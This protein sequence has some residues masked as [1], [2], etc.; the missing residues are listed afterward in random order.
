[1]SK[2]NSD[3][4]ALNL[5]PQSTTVMS[6]VENVNIFSDGEDIS[7]VT[8]Y[9]FLVVLITND[10]YN[11]EQIKKLLLLL[12]VLPLL[13]LLLLLLLLNRSSKHWYLHVS[14][15]AEKSNYYQHNE[16]CSFV[17]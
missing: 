16:V 12:L 5:N 17:A 4:V 1:M 11:N 10:S 15:H 7:T 3:R 2:K 6:I 9:R 14:H 13:L 8:N